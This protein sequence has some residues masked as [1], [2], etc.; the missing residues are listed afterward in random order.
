MYLSY[1]FLEQNALGNRLFSLLGWEIV[2]LI[3][4]LIKNL[5]YK[6]S[7]FRLILMNTEAFLTN[8]NMF[9][10]KMKKSSHFY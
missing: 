3:I 8:V 6:S 4:L 7:Y 5:R 9:V 10:K 2:L 1:S